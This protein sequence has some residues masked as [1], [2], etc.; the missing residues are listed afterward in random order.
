[1]DPFGKTVVVVRFLRGDRRIVDSYALL[2]AVRFFFFK[3]E[4]K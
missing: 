4:I 1:M 3:Y 2:I